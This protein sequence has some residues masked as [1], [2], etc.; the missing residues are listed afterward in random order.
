MIDKNG[1]KRELSKIEF[2]MFCE[3]GCST[4]IMVGNVQNIKISDGFNHY[5]FK[6][7]YPMCLECRKIYKEAT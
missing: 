1:Q 4:F 5:S 6:N 3:C 7:K 2:P